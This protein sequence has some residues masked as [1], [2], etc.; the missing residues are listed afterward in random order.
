MKIAVVSDSTADMPRAT[1]EA[2]GIRMVALS[3]TFGAQTFRVGEDLS[4]DEFWARMTA[5][6]APFPTTAAPSPGAFQAAFEAAFAAGADAI[7][8]VN[9]TQTLSA[10]VSSARIAA[11]MMPD[12]EI[13]VLDTGTVSMGVGLLALMA[14]EL[15]ATGTPAAEVAARLE[16]R[17][18]DIDLYVG[19]DT[20]AYLRKGGRISGPRATIG[21]LLSVKPII[22]VREGLVEIADKPRTRS[23]ARERVLELLSARRLE[24]LAI[25]YSPPADAKAF[26]DELVAR[27]PGGLD[28]AHVS[29]QPIGPSVGPHIGPG[30]LGAVVLLARD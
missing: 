27:L 23:R 28:P 5:P 10:T 18:G 12:R 14:T 25:L 26:R 15:A 7:V 13:H 29:V 3:V 6:D 19:L 30:A 9:I 22:T 24:R 16:S 17:K 1:A 21:T 11:G 2:A 20:I 8:C 4:T